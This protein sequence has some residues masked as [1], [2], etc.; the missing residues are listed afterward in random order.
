MQRIHQRRTRNQSDLRR[1]WRVMSL[2]ERFEQVVAAIRRPMHTPPRR[3][4]ALRARNDQSA[5]AFPAPSPTTRSRPPDL[6]A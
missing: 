6:A 5:S 4:G 3:S 2:S 1:Y